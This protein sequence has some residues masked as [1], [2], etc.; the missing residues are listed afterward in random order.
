MMTTRRETMRY[1][2]TKVLG[3]DIYGHGV[4]RCDAAG[5]A[6]DERYIGCDT[7]DSERRIKKGDIVEEIDDVGG[8]R[9]VEE[10]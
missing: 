2:V 7:V 4:D 6:G 3:A 1:H 5:C 10:E 9:A 8:L